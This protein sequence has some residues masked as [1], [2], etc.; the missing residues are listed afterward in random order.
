METI[1]NCIQFQHVRYDANF[2]EKER[3]GDVYEGRIVGAN[4]NHPSKKYRGY[5]VRV[6]GNELPHFVREKDILR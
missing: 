2:N 4:L 5:I 1:G 3:T 6:E